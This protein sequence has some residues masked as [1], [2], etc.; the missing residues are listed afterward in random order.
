MKGSTYC[1]HVMMKRAI[2]S[3]YFGDISNKTQYSTLIVCITLAQYCMSREGHL[4]LIFKYRKSRKNF[5]QN[6]ADGGQISFSGMT[7]FYLFL[8]E[9]LLQFHSMK[10]NFWRGDVGASMSLR[11]SQLATDYNRTRSLMETSICFQR[12]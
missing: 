1:F 8:F 5:D 6:S 10:D 4:Q 11:D 7:N 3:R 2:H 9:R 12:A